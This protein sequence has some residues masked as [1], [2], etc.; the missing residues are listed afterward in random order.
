MLKKGALIILLTILLSFS[1]SA[2]ANFS[3]QDGYDWLAGEISSDG[4][5]NSDVF[6]TSLAV[7]ALDDQS[8]DTASSQDWLIS[9]MDETDLCLA[10][11]SCTVEETASSV[12]A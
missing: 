12:I 1:V 4:S 9:Q 10:A 8:Y 3:A 11:S 2:A 6:T 5:F 7:L